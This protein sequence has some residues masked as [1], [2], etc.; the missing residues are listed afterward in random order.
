MLQKLAGPDVVGVL[1]VPLQIDLIRRRQ[2]HQNAG[3]TGGPVI[4]VGD[5]GGD[6]IHTHVGGVYGREAIEGQLS[7]AGDL[8]KKLVQV[9]ESIGSG[10]N[11]F[12]RGVLAEPIQQLGQ[13]VIDERGKLGGGEA[14][15]H[16]GHM[17][18]HELIDPAGEVDVHAALHGLPADLAEAAVRGD[19]RG[20]DGAVGIGGGVG[21]DGD[22]IGEGNAAAHG[23]DL[24]GDHGLGGG[25]QNGQG[26]HIG[27]HD[28]DVALFVTLDIAGGDQVDTGV[29]GSGLAVVD[30]AVGLNTLVAD[31]QI[32]LIGHDGGTGGVDHFHVQ[33]LSLVVK[34]TLELGA[35]VIHNLNLNAIGEDGKGTD[36][37][38][39]I[40][41]LIFKLSNVGKLGI[42]AVAKFGLDDLGIQI[43]IVET[44]NELAVLIHAK[45]E[46]VDL[47]TSMVIALG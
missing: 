32:L 2:D 10:T 14:V 18:S 37:G 28:H 41:H 6:Q 1:V 3:I 20:D 17:L 39:C 8:G 42:G 19:L 44:G 9:G 26:L 40:V 35:L 13:A 43:F 25:R 47:G 5:H 46:V 24:I 16:A 29:G 33:L 34:G 7:A 27:A 22:E 21:A 30:L 38:N 31:G 11:Q 15:L 4:G 12:L 36:D 45:E 23:H